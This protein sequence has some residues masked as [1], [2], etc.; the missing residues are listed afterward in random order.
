MSILIKSR[1]GE[2]PSVLGSPI[3]RVAEFIARRVHAFWQQRALAQI[4]RFDDRMLHDIELFR[5]DIDAAESLPRSC[6]P[7]AF[8]GSLRAG[9]KNAQ[10]RT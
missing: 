9:R 7:I 1:Q 2:F 6:D 5:N 10:E 3:E 8:L 4:S